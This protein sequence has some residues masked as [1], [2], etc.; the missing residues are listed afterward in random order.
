MCGETVLEVV[1][2]QQQNVS[3]DGFGFDVTVPDGAVP[4]GITISLAVKA[5]LAGQ[6]K[7]PDN[8]H[9]VSA[10]YWVSASKAFCKEVSVKIQHCA[11]IDSEEEAS[12]YSFVVGKCSQKDLPYTFK[13][14][15]GVFSPRSQLATI[16]VKQFS[17]FGAGFIGEEEDLKRRFLAYS[18]LKEVTATNWEIAFLIT[19]K[20]DLMLQVGNSFIA[21]LVY[22]KSWGGCGVQ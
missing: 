3:W 20:S 11:I 22:C 7:F 4:S 19:V 15:K 21:I 5:I 12:N 10:I 16:S 17:F 14:V 2:N 8:T 1:G 9:L 6:F 18:F 13:L